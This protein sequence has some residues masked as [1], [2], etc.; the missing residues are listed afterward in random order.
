MAWR[1][2]MAWPVRMSAILAAA[3]LAHSAGARVTVE[4]AEITRPDFDVSAFSRRVSGEEGVMVEV[5]WENSSC[6][7]VQNRVEEWEYWV[8]EMD[9]EEGVRNTFQLTTLVDIILDTDKVVNR[10]EPWISASVLI[11]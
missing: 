1:A 8:T 4:L 3:C 10:L 2:V 11:R 6:P 9:G 7:G 5:S